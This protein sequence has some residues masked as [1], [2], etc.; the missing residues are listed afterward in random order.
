MPLILLGWGNLRVSFLL[1]GS[2]TAGCV[3]F[4]VGIALA[5]HANAKAT[6]QAVHEA[7]DSCSLA[8]LLEAR[9]WMAELDYEQVIAITGR[10]LKSEPNNLAALVLRGTG[11]WAP[12]AD[13]G[14]A[15]LRFQR[16]QWP[17]SPEFGSP[18]PISPTHYG[19]GCPRT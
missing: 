10:L 1:L 11:G 8:L 3:R 17:V 18:L 7:A 15:L 12:P 16:G 2:S 9:I 4:R 14:C 19:P 6:L 5:G 13:N